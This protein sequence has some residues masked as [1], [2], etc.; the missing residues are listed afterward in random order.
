MHREQMLE[1][2]LATLQ[3]LVLSTKA[4]SEG[5]WQVKSV[6]LI[7]ITN[8]HTTTFAFPA[9][10]A[11]H[12]TAMLL[13]LGAHHC[14]SV[15]PACTALSSKSSEMQSSYV[16]YCITTRLHTTFSYAHVSYNPRHILP[17]SCGS[18]WGTGL[19]VFNSLLS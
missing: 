6:M 9:F 7:F 2:K 14:R 5:S 15:F 16:C 3:S 18:Y 4:A 1:N 11:E 17:L 8:L 13:L 12:L 10:A 19:Y